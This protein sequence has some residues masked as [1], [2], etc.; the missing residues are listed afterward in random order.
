MYVMG[1]WGVAVVFGVV[2]VVAVVAVT[3]T[4]TIQVI[5]NI[6]VLDI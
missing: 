3:K 2:V 1:T 6:C 4:T 5:G